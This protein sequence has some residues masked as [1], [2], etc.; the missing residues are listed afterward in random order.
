MLNRTVIF[1]HHDKDCIIDNYVIYYLKELQKIANRIVFVSDCN[2]CE[3]ELKKLD[4][5]TIH[6]IANNHGEYDWGSYKY[7]YQY[8]EENNLLE[9]IDVII[10][11]NDSVYGPIYPIENYI[12][13]MNNNKSDFTGF[14]KNNYD[15]YE[16]IGIPHIQSWFILLKRQV[17]LSAEF[18]NFIYSVKHLDDRQDIVD[19]YEIGFTD[20]MSKHFTYYCLYTSENYDA[21][22]RSP[23]KL[24][25]LGFPFCKV[26]IVTKYNIYK[27]LEKKNKKLCTLIK[28]HQG[29]CYHRNIIINSFRPLININKIVSCK[30]IKSFNL[31]V[32]KLIK[33]NYDII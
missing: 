4:G 21:V 17:F 29:R 33:G 11:C 23:L 3:T 20:R 10:F 13:E 7:G 30:I 14:F 1:A 16:K 22:Y 32:D 25:N 12:D 9:N 31:Q 6:N 2:L 5:I 15:S 24:I 26:K 27:F 8:L 19:T 28:K 18:K